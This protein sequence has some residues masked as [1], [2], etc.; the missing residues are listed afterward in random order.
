MRKR[1]AEELKTTF[2]SHYTDEVSLSEALQVD[3]VRR[4]CAKT[5]GEK[6]LICPQ[7]DL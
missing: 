3:V 6:F 4:Y 7:K 5:T 2:V 1:V